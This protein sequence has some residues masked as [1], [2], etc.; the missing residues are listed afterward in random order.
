M[1]ELALSL[2]EENKK[3][4]AK[5]LDL[6]N[7]GLTEVPLEIGELV[8]LEELNFSTSWYE[9]AG[10]TWVEIHSE[11]RGAPNIFFTLSPVLSDL[12]N[13]RALL[14]SGLRLKEISPIASLR[15][16][17]LLDIRSNDISDISFLKNLQNLQCIYMRSN[18]IADL[19][20]LAELKQL[21]ILDIRFNTITSLTPLQNLIGLEQIWAN[22][23]GI[24]DITPLKNLGNLKQLD[25]RWNKVK[26]L[27]P[28]VPLINT[29]IPVQWVWGEGEGIFVKECPF[30]DPPVEIVRQGNQAILNYFR[31]KELQ[32]T[33]KGCE[34]KMLI[35]GE[36][37]AGKTS[38][39]RRLYQTNKPLPEENEST[40]GI[41]IYRHDFKMADGSDFRLNVWDFGGQ[42]IYHATHQFFLTKRSLYVLLDDTRKD[43][44]TVHDEGFKYWLEAVDLFGGHSPVLIFQNEKS[45]RSK[46]IDIGGIKGKFDNVQGVWKGNLEHPGAVDRL[47]EAVELFAKNLPHVGE[48]LPAKWVSIRSE[49]EEIAKTEPYISQQEYFKV[50]GRH[51]EFDREKALY[52]SQYLHDLGIFL[53]FHDDSLLARIVILQNTWAT[54]AV[55][56]M[57]DDES[58]K[59]KLGSFTEADCQRVWNDSTWT[60]MH[61]E[62]LALM[63]KFE[64]CYVLPDIQPKTWL[65]PQ[66][67]PP[68]KPNEL[69]DWAQPGDLVL[70]YRYDFL[71]KGLI[72]RLMV[73]Q[74]RFVP[75]PE[76][77]WTSGLLFERDDSQV[78][79]EI[80]PKGGEIVLRARGFERKELLNVITTDLDA[81]NKAFQG[82]EERVSK[83]IP[84]N[85]DK[86]QTLAEPEFYEQK[87]LLQRKRD[88]KLT[89]ECPGSYEDVDVLEL[90]DGVS[91]K[92][93]PSW[94]KDGVKEATVETIAE[95]HGLIGEGETRK[96]LEIFQKINPKEATAL[97][98]NFAELSKQ[99]NRNLLREEDFIREK[100]KINSAMLDLLDT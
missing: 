23:N 3:T 28:I 84:C 69:L 48:E 77:A 32:G 9:W 42:E 27:K 39:M 40:K 51:L 45:D 14:L 65:V 34:A 63:Q 5:N 57:L 85:C 62:L 10:D 54:E 80:S 46:Q 53:H 64:L 41:D 91:V 20:S 2:I 73:R 60:D 44:K 82:L 18:Q 47:R 98:G 71:P 74:H 89:V 67:L 21:K 88:G 94:A 22:S 1:S 99:R 30:E 7:C 8:W 87:R 37:G 83:L 4:K 15:A 13:L 29:G 25:I 55:F 12:T 6:G 58:V 24:I 36:G 100:A 26:S 19:N 78:L 43:H 38:L 35:L 90:L 16:L 96:A 72:S 56:K 52:L 33:V 61:P 76:M 50:Y 75:H 31:E 79:V 59:V 17:Q 81:L 86:C 70:R 92:T 97:L 68:S 66:L 11:N 95:I 93:L 49:L